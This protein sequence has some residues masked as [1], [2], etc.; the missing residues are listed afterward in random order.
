MTQSDIDYL[1]NHK[2]IFD[3]DDKQLQQNAISEEW[4]AKIIKKCQDSAVNTWSIKEIV[5]I[6]VWNPSKPVKNLIEKWIE[7]YNEE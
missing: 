4:V 3:V 1:L 6:Y 7:H 5:A 2:C